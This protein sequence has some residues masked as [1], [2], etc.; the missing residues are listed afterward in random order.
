M[1]SCVFHQEMRY[2]AKCLEVWVRAAMDGFPSALVEAKVER[3]RA[4]AHSIRRYTSLNHLAQVCGAVVHFESVVHLRESVVVV[5]AEVEAG[6]PLSCSLCMGT[7]ARW[8]AVVSFAR[9]VLQGP[10]PLC[11]RLRDCRPPLPKEHV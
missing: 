10:R 5:G 1:P 6:V 9:R 3:V 2:F 11:M 8:I 4:F 7:T